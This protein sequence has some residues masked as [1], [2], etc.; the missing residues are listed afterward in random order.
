MR[1]W[2]EYGLSE[3]DYTTMLNGQGGKCAICTK[4]LGNDVCVD[5]DHATG[6]VRALLCRKCNLGLG[7]LMDDPEVL[8]A[9][10]AYVERYR[11][12]TP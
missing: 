4:E 3:A 6:M 9:A 2:K 12:N 7:Y 11:C 8:R 5:H 1:L 10:A